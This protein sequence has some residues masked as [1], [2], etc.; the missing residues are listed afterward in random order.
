MIMV[1]GQADKKA[2]IE[3]LRYGA[4]DFFEKPVHRDELVETIKERN[5][6]EN[7]YKD[8]ARSI[9]GLTKELAEEKAEVERLTKVRQDWMDIYYELEEDSSKLKAALEVADEYIKVSR[10]DTPSS[11]PTIRSKLLIK[12]REA[13][14]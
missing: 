8:Q 10:N 3:A 4:F 13:R 11:D 14:K 12:Y 9:N 6:L 2:A 1:T 5:I 7:N